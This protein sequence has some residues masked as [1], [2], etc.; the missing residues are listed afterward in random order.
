M[1]LWTMENVLSGFDMALF[2][3]LRQ[4]LDETGVVLFLRKSQI[5]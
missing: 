3:I 1:P 5:L 4:F 2:Y